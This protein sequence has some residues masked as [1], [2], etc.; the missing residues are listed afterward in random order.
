MTYN[1]FGGTLN[2]TLP[3]YLCALEVSSVLLPGD[4]CSGSLHFL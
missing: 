4:H 3:I 1:V 2:L